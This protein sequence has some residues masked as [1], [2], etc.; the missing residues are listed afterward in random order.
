VLI[1]SSSELVP[2]DLNNLV[3]DAGRDWDVLLDPRDMFNDRNLDRGDIIV[4][5]STF[6]GFGPG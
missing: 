1:N 6:L 4:T 2:K 5:K 3:K